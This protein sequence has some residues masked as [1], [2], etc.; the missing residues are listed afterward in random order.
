MAPRSPILFAAV[1]AVSA[2]AQTAPLDVDSVAKRCTELGE[3]AAFLTF[4]EGTG[5]VSS[6]LPPDVRDFARGLRARSDLTE[7]Q[8]VLAARSLG[9]GYCIGVAVTKANGG[10]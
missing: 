4:G 3:R 6:S 2:S 10:K 9:A 5:T 7:D 8:R 1:V